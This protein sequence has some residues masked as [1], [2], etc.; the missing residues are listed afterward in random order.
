MIWT[1]LQMTENKRAFMDNFGVWYDPIAL[2]F[3]FTNIARLSLCLL[4][5]MPFIAFHEKRRRLSN[6]DKHR[7]A[8]TKWEK[9]KKG[10]RSNYRIENNYCRPCYDCMQYLFKH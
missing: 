7:P 4:Q 2:S 5:N 8:T 1:L 9:K 6:L 10:R 3:C